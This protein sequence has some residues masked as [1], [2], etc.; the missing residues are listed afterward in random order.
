MYTRLTER[1]GEDLHCLVLDGEINKE[2]LEAMWNEIFEK[3]KNNPEQTFV[4][5]I[6]SPGG[7]FL[8][9]YNFYMRVRFWG[10][11]LVTVGLGAV[12]S[13]GALLFLA[14]YERLALRGAIFLFHN[15]QT[16]VDHAQLDKNDHIKFVAHLK[17]SE[18]AQQQLLADE[19]GLNKRAIRK[20]L[21]ADRQIFTDEALKLGIVHEIIE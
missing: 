8:A 20:L 2:V 3:F 1:Y 11:K 21:S 5:I 7:E 9:T 6:T 4:L 15:S 12:F 17:T 10:V 13:A 18:M 19:L 16:H 14:G